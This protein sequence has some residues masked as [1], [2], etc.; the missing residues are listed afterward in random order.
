MIWDIVTTLSGLTLILITNWLVM[1]G[2]G[3]HL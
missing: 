3:K 2:C 1:R